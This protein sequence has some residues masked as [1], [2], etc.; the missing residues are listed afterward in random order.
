[1]VNI[2]SLSFQFCFKPENDLLAFVSHV[3]LL[4]MPTPLYAKL[5][6]P[7][8]CEMGVR[9]I[10]YQSGNGQGILIHVLGINL[11]M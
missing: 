3:R 11:A 7:M 6:C 8:K 4:Q 5:F 2:I 10:D 9:E 1:M